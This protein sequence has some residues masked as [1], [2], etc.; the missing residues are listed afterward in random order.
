MLLT[1][2]PKHDS[3]RA[4]NSDIESKWGIAS[5]E[6]IDS[7]NPQSPASILLFTHIGPRP[8]FA[9]VLDCQNGGQKHADVF[10]INMG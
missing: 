5:I 1:E 7:K 6:E 2:V 4:K 3:M 10:V 8:I 9:Y